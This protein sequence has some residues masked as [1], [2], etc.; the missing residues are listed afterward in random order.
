M[1]SRTTRQVADAPGRA[2]VWAAAAALAVLTLAGCAATTSL[3][4]ARLAERQ[5]DWDRAVVEYTNALR[6]NPSDQSARLALERAKLRSTDIHLTRARRLASTGRLEEALVEYQVA[7]QMSPASTAIEDAL[8]DVRAKLRARVAVARDGKTQL[9]TLIERARELPPPGLDLPT[10]L[11]L[12]DSLVFREASSRDV[13]TAVARFADVNIVFDP[14]FRDAPIT[15]DLRKSTFDQALVSLT[16]STHNFYR[17]TAPRTITLI[18]DTPAKRREYE[19]EVIRTFYLSNVEVKET[20]DLLRIVV[21]ARRIAPIAGT[22]AI[23]LKDT[24]ERVA[25]AGRIIAAVDKARPE[26]VVDVEV[27]EV[28]RTKLREFGL[29]IASAGSAGI[30]GAAGI[31]RETL[32]L[33]DLQTLTSADVFLTNFPALFYRLLKSDSSSRTLANPQLRSQDGVAAQARFGE[34][35]PV[36]VTTFSPIATGGVNQQPITS[37]N[38]ENIGVNIDITPRMHHN[39]DVSLA[40]KL[41]VSSISGTGYGDLPTFGNRSVSTLIRLRDGETSVL[42]GLIRDDERVVMDGIPGLSNLPLIGRLFAKNRRETQ[43][44]DIILT[45]TPHIVR[46]LD[47]TENDLRPFLVGR[48]LGTAFEIPAIETPRED[49]PA[50]TLPKPGIIIK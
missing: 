8:R 32:T 48:D 1:S 31:S 11:K 9:Q 43:E 24:P 50:V 2:R 44:T 17:V 23:T 30:S 14:A 15:V 20:I 6:K 19:E 45:L 13:F 7:Q 36:P 34:R 47:I 49:Q 22:N 28:D 41:E 40:V 3:S 5:E 39:D 21:D 27:L 29:Q 46:V 42:A 16:A 33:R 18:P 4:Q 10:G 12:P 26:V 35:V 37:F 38:Y 25:A